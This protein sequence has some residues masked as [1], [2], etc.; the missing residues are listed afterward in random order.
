MIPREKSYWTIRRRVKQK[1]QEC[2]LEVSSQNKAS[3]N[4]HPRTLDSVKLQNGDCLLENSGSSSNHFTDNVST[5]SSDTESDMQC[6]VEEKHSDDDLLSIDQGLKNDADIFNLQAEIALWATSCKI[7]QCALHSLLSILRVKHPDLPKDPR[8]LLGTCTSYETKQIS[9]GQY[10]H[11]GISTCICKELK[12]VSLLPECG[13]T[14]RL[15]INIDGLPLFKST[16][17]QF[18]EC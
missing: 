9:G 7:N 14:L 1:V 6:Q 5:S 18:W 17:D 11:F 8:T 13:S 4:P 2:Y 10:Y 3:P 16:N 12:R 15:Q